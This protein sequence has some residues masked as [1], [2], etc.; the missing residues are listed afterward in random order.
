MRSLLHTTL[1]RASTGT[2]LL[3]LA[4]ATANAIVPVVFHR[5]EAHDT[6]AHQIYIG[7]NDNWVIVNGDHTT[8][9]DC[10]I[11]DDRGREVDHDTDSTDTCLLRTPGIGQHRLVVENLGDVYNDYTITKYERLR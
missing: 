7:V 10:W 9:L 8:D 5:V 2:L 3:G 1:R 4:V 6:N 11:Y